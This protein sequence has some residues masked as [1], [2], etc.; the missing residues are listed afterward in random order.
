MTENF[1]LFKPSGITAENVTLTVDLDDWFFMR[2]MQERVIEIPG[3]IEEGIVQLCQR[4]IIQINQMDKGIPVDER[5]PIKILIS[6]DGGDTFAGLE[7]IDM[8][9]NSKTPVW[10]VNMGHEYS[11]AAIVG[12]AGNKRYATKN[13]SFL[14][15]DG[16]VSIQD[17]GSKVHDFIKFDK[18]LNERIKKFVLSRSNITAQKYSS[19]ARNEWYFFADEAKKLGMVDGIIGEDIELE[20]II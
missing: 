9:Q 10:T 13:A 8:I 2:T 5:V 20:E 7:L 18:Q 14:I 15:H 4:S 11:M 17:S 6:S 1:D 19:K 3:I 16:A 12:L